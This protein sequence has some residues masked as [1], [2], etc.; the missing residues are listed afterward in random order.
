M[1]PAFSSLALPVLD[2]LLLPLWRPLFVLHR[3]RFIWSDLPDAKGG[4]ARNWI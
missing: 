4:P 3:R 1:T 2:I